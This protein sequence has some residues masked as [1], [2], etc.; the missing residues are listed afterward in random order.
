MQNIIKNV[1]SHSDEARWLK[2]TLADLGDTAPDHEAQQENSRLTVAIQRYKDLMPTIEV[3]ETKSSVVVRC[4]DYKEDIEEKMEW[5]NEAEDKVRE[6]IPLDDL[7][8][9]RVL[10][11]EQEVKYIIYIITVCMYTSIRTAGIYIYIYIYILYYIFAVDLQ[12]KYG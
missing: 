8:S 3:T 5:L 7:G 9:V 12:C 6:D 11:E 10:L 2:K 1:D 4:Y